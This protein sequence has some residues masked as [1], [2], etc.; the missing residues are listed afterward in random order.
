MTARIVG[1]RAGLIFE[2]NLPLTA[3]LIFEPDLHPYV[4]SFNFALVF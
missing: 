1:G 3:A 2:L 4:P